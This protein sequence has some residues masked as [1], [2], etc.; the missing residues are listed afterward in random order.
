MFQFFF[1]FLQIVDGYVQYSFDCGSGQG[2]TRVDKIAV[3]DGRWHT[4]Q[5]H[6]A[7][8]AVRLTVDKMY[9][10]EGM[11]P[12]TNEV[13]NL[14]SNELFFG[15]EV[16][17]SHSGYEN[18]REGFKGCMRNVR[19]EGMDL[20]LQGSNRVGSF[21]GQKDLEYHCNGPYV[22]GEFYVLICLTFCFLTLQTS[23]M[24][25]YII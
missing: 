14:N 18:V 17:I 6:R 5:V 1:V 24:I 21:V 7:G 13:L 2:L 15:G 23:N 20:P 4:V 25:Y 11:G 10:N 9:T 3:N 8:K 22:P 16:D 19:I 12:G